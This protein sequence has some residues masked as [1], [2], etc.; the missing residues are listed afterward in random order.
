MAG[1]RS[2]SEE[3]GTKTKG[4]L[5][6]FQVISVPAHPGVLHLKTRQRNIT[7][8][9]GSNLINCWVLTLKALSQEFKFG[10]YKLVWLIRRASDV[11]CCCNFRV[12][13]Y[14][15]CQLTNPWRFE[16]LTAKCLLTSR[17]QPLSRDSKPSRV[18][19]TAALRSRSWSRQEPKLGRSRYI[20]A[21]FGCGSWL[22]VERKQY[23]LS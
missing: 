21:S 9:Q 3:Y 8:C 22:R 11:F 7:F 20:L 13:L 1:K 4:S 18:A 14:L 17:G 16:G 6:R 12:V 10:F 23:I 19:R 15:N 5:H 2:F